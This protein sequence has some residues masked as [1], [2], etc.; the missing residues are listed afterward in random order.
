MEKTLAGKLESKR[1]CGC[2]AV[3][4]RLPASGFPLYPFLREV[5]ATL[6]SISGY[7]RRFP[8]LSWP[9]RPTTS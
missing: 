5:G 7:L 6:L 1:G 4:F 8:R 3:D 9:K 2:A